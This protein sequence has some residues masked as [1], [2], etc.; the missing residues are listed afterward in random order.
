MSKQM[1]LDVVQ[2]AAVMFFNNLTPEVYAVGGCVR[3]VFLGVE[4]KDTDL[5]VV[6]VTP[7]QMTDMGFIATGPSAPVFRH[8]ALRDANGKSVEVALARGERKNG[9]GHN[10]FEFFLSDNLHD[11]LARR[12]FTVNAMAFSSNGM[13]VDPFHG[14]HDLHSRVLRHVGPEFSEDPLRVYRAARFA[15]KLGFTVAPSTME[16]MR[17]FG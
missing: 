3:D 9:L 10:G 16:L 1:V 17:T 7:Q 4:S 11:D 5:V 12:D 13:L 14:L 6:G 15:A 8:P 2:Q